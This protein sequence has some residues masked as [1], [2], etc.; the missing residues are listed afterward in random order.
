[1]LYDTPNGV[2]IMAT[3]LGANCGADEHWCALTTISDI[4]IETEE[5]GHRALASSL[6]VGVHNTLALRAE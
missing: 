4:Y 1:M 2:A 3:Q 5:R 6:T